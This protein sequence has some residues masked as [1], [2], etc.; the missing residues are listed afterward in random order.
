MLSTA[1]NRM[2]ISK[3]VDFFW[4]TTIILSWTM[5]SPVIFQISASA[6][7]V[8]TR[9]GLIENL[10]VSIS[11]FHSCIQRNITVRWIGWAI[12]LVKC[13]VSCL[14]IHVFHMS[15]HI[16]IIRENFAT[17]RIFKVHK[18]LWISIGVSSLCSSTFYGC[19]ACTRVI[20]RSCSIHF[21]KKV[22][23]KIRKRKFLWTID[24]RYYNV[25]K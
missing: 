13:L 23:N 14:Q 1:T 11:G 25:N 18:Y 6:H 20:L 24:F 7:A 4:V 12:L 15:C 17:F 8:K 9:H 16:L 5:T 2:Y 22:A 19:E 3:G 10:L 21:N